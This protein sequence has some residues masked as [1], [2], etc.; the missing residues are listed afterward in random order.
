MAKMKKLKGKLVLSEIIEGIS[1]LNDDKITNWTIAEISQALSGEV[2]ELQNYLK[3]KYSQDEK[4][5]RREIEGE[6]ADVLKY[7]ITLSIA[8]DIN[9]ETAFINKVNKNIKIK[10]KKY[11][12]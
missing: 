10:N 5:K 12:K 7:L 11:G 4:V 8:C 9:L 6:F 1:V 3:K 2:G